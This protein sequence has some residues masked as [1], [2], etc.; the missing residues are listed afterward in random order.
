MKRCPWPG[1]DA[2]M[3][4]YHDEEWGVPVHDDR[5]HFEF[6]VLESAQ[7]GLSW[8]TILNRRDGYRRAYEGFDPE[9]IAGYGPL[10]IERLVADSGIV[11]NRRKIE[12]SVNNARRLLETAREFGSF[13]AYLWAFV[14]GS[15]VVGAWEE[16]GEIPPSTPLSDR[17]SIDLKKR[18]FT[19]IGTTIVYSHLQ[20]TGLV[21]DHVKACFR[22]TELTGER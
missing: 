21:N 1:N 13:S 6:L 18:G 15:P 19:F 9:R 8:R 5:T 20:A 22:F 11:R 14:G 4:R 10:D 2:A 3:L 17:I 16:I 12:A 7:A